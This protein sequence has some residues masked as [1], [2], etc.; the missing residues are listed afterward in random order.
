VYCLC[1][2]NAGYIFLKM[3]A[4]ANSYLWFKYHN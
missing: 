2:N 1:S 4:K 3:R